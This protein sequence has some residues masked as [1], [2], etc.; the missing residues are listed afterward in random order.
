MKIRTDYVNNSSSSSFML[1]VDSYNGGDIVFYFK[2][3]T[4]KNTEVKV[5][6]SEDS[7]KAIDRERYIAHTK[8]MGYEKDQ[9]CIR[10][11]KEFDEGRT[12]L[13]CFVADDNQGTEDC[14][15]A[16]EIRFERADIRV[17]AP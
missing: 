16:E 17:V 2:C 14:I 13:S 7:I 5:E 10:V 15:Y 12:V 9:Y 3:G 8:D 11:I 4:D 1:S 6:I